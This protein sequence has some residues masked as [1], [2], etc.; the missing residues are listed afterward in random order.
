MCPHTGLS[1]FQAYSEALLAHPAV[2]A[3]IVPPDSSK[4]YVEH[5]VDTYKEYVARRKAAAN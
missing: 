5:M 3:S 4:S 1:R 2:A